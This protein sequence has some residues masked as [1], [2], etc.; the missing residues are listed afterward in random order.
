M[1]LRKLCRNTYAQSLYI[2]DKLFG[3][4]FESHA[5]NEKLQLSKDIGNPYHASSEWAIRKC[6]ASFSIKGTDGFFDF[7]CG[8]GAILRLA[9]KY[10]FG[11]IGGGRNKRKSC[12]NSEEKF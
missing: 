3:V 5:S 11:S 1:N 7:G 8:K 6:L 12:I 2:R 9:T 4:D 10:P